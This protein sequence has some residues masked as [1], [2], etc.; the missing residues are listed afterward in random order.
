MNVNALVTRCTNTFS[1][2][3]KSLA[4][5][6]SLAI[7]NRSFKDF[8]WEKF[9]L[10]DR[11]DNFTEIKDFWRFFE[12]SRDQRLGA[13]YTPPICQ[14]KIISKIKINEQSKYLDP[15]V[16]TGN[17]LLAL[18]DKIL[19][20]LPGISI[21]KL[22]NSLYAFDLDRE[23]LEL[24][25]LNI[26]LKL[27]QIYPSAV[28]DRVLYEKLKFYETDFTVKPHTGF[29]FLIDF[30]PIYIDSKC[31]LDLK[32]AEKFDYV[33]SNPPFI[34]FYGRRSKKLPEIHRQYYL[35]SYEFIPGEI[36]NGKLNS[37]MFFIEHGLNLLKE[38]GQLIYLLDNSIYETSAYF[39]RKWVVSNFQINS[40]DIGLADFDRVA[41][42]QTI[43][44]ITKHIPKNPV[45]LRNLS[46]G[47]EQ[48]INQVKWLENAE[49]KIN[50]IQNNFILQKMRSFQS[51]SHY[52]P[53]K[54]I[55][56]CCM[57]L[58]LT[59]QFLVE[60]E[61]YER[62]DS[63]LIMPYLEG[64]KSLSH[65]DKPFKIYHHIKYDRDLQLRL[66]EEIRKTLEQKG[67]KNKKRIGL[68]PLEMY[69]S[70][71]LFI[72]Q[73]S[74][75]LIVKFTRENLMANNSLYILTPIYSAFQKEEWEKVLI[76]TERLLNSKLYLY[77]AYKLDVIRK[78]V[79]QQPQIKVGDLRQLPF[80][81]DITSS[82]FYEIINLS[83]IQRDKIDDMI[84]HYLNL[85]PEEINEIECFVQS[86]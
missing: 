3:F 79:K 17:L 45:L 65:P 72:R 35:K 19:T 7:Q 27:Q 76:Y 62:D 75:R 54:S 25:K 44:Q 48:K 81:I 78:N 71:K 22:I 63:G 23:A 64:G 51:I 49:C 30:N 16:G 84:Y 21:D 61:I 24:A 66:S 57:L 26:L 36:K 8:I 82:W 6:L 29:D 46:T 77:M 20:E 2:E 47:V 60:K 70:P 12:Q 73:S 86:V 43:W 69:L 10:N 85:T 74:H 80:W 37:Y 5:K 4:I 15:G 11:D 56:T 32:Q 13:F 42:G 58:D 67:I 52:F 33:I 83:P 31:V 28:I 50:F 55:R 1:P 59:E 14:E 40:I 68:G 38:G 39:L 18:I 41:S 53:G 9:E 34:T